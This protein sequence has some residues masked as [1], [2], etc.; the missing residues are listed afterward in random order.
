MFV[1]MCRHARRHVQICVSTCAHT[2]H[3]RAHADV[4]TFACMPA[5][6]PHSIATRRPLRRPGP[7]AWPV[8]MHALNRQ[9]R[10]QPRPLARC[11][12]W[13][14]RGLRRCCRKSL[15]TSWPEADPGVCHGHARA[16]RRRSSSERLVPLDGNGAV[17]GWAQTGEPLKAWIRRREDVPRREKKSGAEGWFLRPWIRR[18]VG[19]LDTG[20]VSAVATSQ[21]PAMRLGSPTGCHASKNGCCAWPV[22]QVASKLCGIS[23]LDAAVRRAWA[24]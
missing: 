15:I 20:G 7:S 11:G 21:A 19:W 2:K 6:R 16:A 23:S 14:R 17:K 18:R 24:L 22:A 3:G 13:Q 4:A 9:R 8:S 1:D 10:Q 12:Q 5:H